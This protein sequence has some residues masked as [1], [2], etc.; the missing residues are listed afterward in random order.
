MCKVT[1]LAGEHEVIQTEMSYF[2]NSYMFTSNSGKGV[3]DG[4]AFSRYFTTALF[5]FFFF[6]S[7]DFGAVQ[8]DFIV[9]EE[10][11][12]P[13]LSHVFLSVTLNYLSL[14]IAHLNNHSDLARCVSFI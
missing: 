13:T 7:P 8:K 11:C 2:T 10:V 12:P 3:G 1:I 5:F 14:W 4:P 6:S 9:S